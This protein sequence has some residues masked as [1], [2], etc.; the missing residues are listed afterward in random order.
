MARRG[1][2]KKVPHLGNRRSYVSSAATEPPGIT[3]TRSHVKG[4]KVWVPLFDET[5]V[6]HEQTNTLADTK[7]KGYDPKKKKYDMC[8]IYIRPQGR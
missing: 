5:A 7:T 2:R 1:G 3:T 8:M 4:V 6:S